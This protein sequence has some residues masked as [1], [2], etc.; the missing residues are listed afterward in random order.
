MSVP[1]AVLCSGGGTNLQ[2]LL[3][4]ARRP[5]CPFRV[6]LVVV[7][8]PTAG[9]RARAEAAG[10]P[11]EVVLLRDHPDRAAYDA[12]VVARLVA[13]GAAWVCLAGWMKQ[14][15]PAFLEAFPGRILNV[16]PSLLPAFPG[17]HAQQQA[18]DAGVKVAGCTVHLV[19]AGLDTGPIVAQEAV[20]VLPDDDAEALRL[21][22]LAAEHRIYAE[23]L[24]WAVTGRLRLDGR[25][26]RVV[27]D[28]A[29]RA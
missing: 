18:F 6:A 24:G 29:A 27:D 26:I 14:V 21:R 10:V 15:G 8:R 7:D 20:A 13:H 2:A 3:D 9:A 28:P 23:A 25:R 12:A 16:H 22:I 4:A 19:D 11:V 1:V 5:G 17:L